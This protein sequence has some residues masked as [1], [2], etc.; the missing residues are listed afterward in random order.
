MQ[1]IIVFDFDKT[2]TNKDTILLFF[3]FCCRKN[4]WLYFAT[5]ILFFNKILSKI[6][7]ISIQK[8]KEIGMCIFCPSNMDDF[9]E[10]C[11]NYS[12]TIKLNN[13]VNQ[14][15]KEYSLQN[16]VIIASASFQYY[17]QPL[18]PHIP[19]I[20]TLVNTS[21]NGKIKNISQHPFQA[22]KWKTLSDYGINYIDEFYTDGHNDNIICDHAKI[23]HWI[24]NGKITNRNE[25]SNF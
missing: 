23:V 1:K 25:N 3:I 8:E 17:I 5:P 2:L 15:N 11:I 16:N 9:K 12:K 7:W 10:T 19:V 13:I 4:P 20:G 21:D 22:E 18:F 6:K 24:C 14:L